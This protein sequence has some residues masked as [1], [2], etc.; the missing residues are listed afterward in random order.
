[1]GVETLFR[2]DLLQKMKHK[3]G[4]GR[5]GSMDRGDVLIGSEAKHGIEAL[6]PS[7]SL[8]FTIIIGS[9]AGAIT[10]VDFRSLF[11]LLSFPAFFSSET[12]SAAL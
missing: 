6:V 3:D 12:V 5:N 8:T 9:P 7:R 1:M 11:S 10:T 2:N 4:K